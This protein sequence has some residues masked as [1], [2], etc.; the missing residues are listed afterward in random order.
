[1]TDD[2]GR[3]CSVFYI[4]GLSQVLHTVTAIQN[5]QNPHFI[6]VLCC[7]PFAPVLIHTCNFIRTPTKG[8]VIA[9]LVFQFAHANQHSLF[10]ILVNKALVLSNTRR[11]RNSENYAEKQLVSNA[12]SDIC[13]EPGCYQLARES[14]RFCKNLTSNNLQLQS[15]LFQAVSFS[16]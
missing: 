1:M 8:P 6:R 4:F 13:T 12:D 10:G 7:I 11:R 2:K 9:C 5:M 16:H 15:R 14:W 3:E